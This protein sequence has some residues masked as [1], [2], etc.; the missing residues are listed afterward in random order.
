MFRRKSLVIV[1]IKQL[2]KQK[3]STT[4]TNVKSK[5]PILYYQKVG[6][7][8]A[9]EKGENQTKNNIKLLTTLESHHPSE[10]LHFS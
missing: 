3:I 7:K 6:R 10:S 8:Q 2:N 9:V 1:L 4:T 5:R